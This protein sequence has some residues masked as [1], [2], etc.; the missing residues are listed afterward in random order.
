A[1]SAAP[2]ASARIVAIKGFA[3]GGGRIVIAHGDGSHVHRLAQG[4]RAQIA[5]NGK[6]V[7]VSN[8]DPGQQATHPRVMVYRASGGKPL[9][10]IRQDIS[11]ISWSPDSTKLAGTQRNGIGSQRLVVIDAGTGARTTLL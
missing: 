5:P 1:L 7:Q 2:V 11:P 9:F 10:V 4:D 6:L 8:Y 3:P